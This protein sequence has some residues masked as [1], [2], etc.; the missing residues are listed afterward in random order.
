MSVGLLFY[1]L[2]VS[3][4]GG[5]IFMVLSVPIGKWT[6]KRTQ[7]YQKILMKRK[8][9]RMS[10]VGETM[11]AR[12]GW[13]APCGTVEATAVV[14]DRLPGRTLVCC[15]SVPSSRRSGSYCIAQ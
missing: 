15:C 14:A 4:I 13:L 2:G 10:V 9:D 8:D 1:V 7:A 6:T 11:Q 5:V 3:A 12:G